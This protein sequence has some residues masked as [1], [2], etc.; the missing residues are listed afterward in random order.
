MRHVAGDLDGAAAYY[1]QATLI[2]PDNAEAR[3]N[4]GRVLSTQSQ[5]AAAV[6]EYRAALALRPDMPSALSGLGWVLATSSNPAVRSPVEAIQVGERAVALTGRNDA[7]A[8]DALAAAYAAAGQ[9]D[10]AVATAGAAVEVATRAKAEAQAAQI[11]GRLAAYER[12]RR[13]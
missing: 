11:R 5:D 2:R 8:L 1:R 3:N 10:R 6:V 7:T 9:W 13:P 12:A 4:L